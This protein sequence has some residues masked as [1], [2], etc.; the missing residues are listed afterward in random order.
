MSSSPESIPRRRVFS[1]L[2]PLRAGLAAMVGL[3]VLASLAG[4]VPPI[5]LGYLIN[6]LVEKHGLKPEDALWAGLL[7]SA[8]LI[9]DCTAD[10]GTLLILYRLAAR[11]FYGFDGLIDLNL[12]VQSGRG[13]INRCLELL[14][15]ETVPDPRSSLG[16]AA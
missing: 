7:A 5:T 11:C 15:R 8:I 13:P 3:S 2:R 1:L 9:E 6:G 14:D 10:A 12:S 16:E 4:L